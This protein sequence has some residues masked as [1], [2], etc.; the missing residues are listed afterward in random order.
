MKQAKPDQMPCSR[1][2]GTGHVPLP[3]ELQMTL[4]LLRKRGSLTAVALFG[5]MEYG[6]A[7]AANNRL[8]S[9]RRLGFARRERVNGKVWK[10][11]PVKP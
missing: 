5:H 7:T 6:G 4:D 3:P 1:C 11:S 9:L 10:Y 8:E 2:T